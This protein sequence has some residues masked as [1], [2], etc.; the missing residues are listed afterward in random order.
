VSVDG[1]TALTIALVNASPKHWASDP[2]E[3]CHRST[4]TGCS[5]TYYWVLGWN[6]RQSWSGVLLS[7]RD[8]E[9]GFRFGPGM[10]LDSHCFGNNGANISGP[11]PCMKYP[12]PSSIGTSFS[13]TVAVHDATSNRLYVD[14]MKVHE[15]PIAHGIAAVSVDPPLNLGNNTFAHN[16]GGDIA[17]LLVYRRALADADREAL[18]RTL[19][20][21]YLPARAR[22]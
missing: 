9:I 17:E 22:R 18:E 2:N 15:A 16:G 13:L 4:P 12:R 1:A 6:G 14:G 5:S 19:L 20:C 10:D 21:T 8:E 11:D 7:P 3:W